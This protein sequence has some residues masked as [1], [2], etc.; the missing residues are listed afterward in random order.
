MEEASLGKC[1]AL[2]QMYPDCCSQLP[3]AFQA[4]H[5]RLHALRE[6]RE[7][8]HADAGLVA[9]ILAA[10][11][12]HC[13]EQESCLLTNNSDFFLIYILDALHAQESPGG[14][15][16]LF[17]HLNCCYMCF[18]EYNPVARDYFH[19]YHKLLHAGASA[20]FSHHR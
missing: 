9:T 20:D 5:G 7:L 11:P 6:R 12:Q 15:F 2:L 8:L 18:E 1:L 16:R 13:C 19:M 14:C 10:L 17:R 3:P 4:W